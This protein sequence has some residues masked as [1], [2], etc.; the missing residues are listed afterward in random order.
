MNNVALRL[1]HKW[2]KGSKTLNLLDASVKQSQKQKAGTAKPTEPVLQQ[3][4]R[5]QSIMAQPATAKVSPAPVGVAASTGGQMSRLPSD[6]T[7]L[8]ESIMRDYQKQQQQPQQQPGRAAVRATM[9]PG[10]VSPDAIMAAGAPSSSRQPQQ[11]P[12]QSKHLSMLPSSSSQHDSQADL[13]R[14]LAKQLLKEDSEDQIQPL[15]KPLKQK[16]MSS[17]PDVSRSE[18]SL[19][20][21]G[22]DLRRSGGSNNRLSRN[23]S[24]RLSGSLNNLA[25]NSGAMGSIEVLAIAT[26][27]AYKSVM[28]DDAVKTEAMRR[29]N[30]KF[31]VTADQ[32]GK[33]LIQD[34]VLPEKFSAESLHLRPASSLGSSRNLASLDGTTAA[35]MSIAGPSEQY[36]GQSEQGGKDGGS[37]KNLSGSLPNMA[38]HASGNRA[39]L[40]ESAGNQ[41]TERAPAAKASPAP[42]SQVAVKDPATQRQSHMIGR[43]G[44]PAE[45]INSLNA[46]V[47]TQG[48]GA[49]AVHVPQNT[50]TTNSNSSIASPA[51]ALP[52]ADASAPSREESLRKNLSMRRHVSALPG[53]A[54]KYR[55]AAEDDLLHS[56]TPCRRM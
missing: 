26:A 38:D 24:Q 46:R 31:K 12:M 4:V 55:T 28:T 37:R 42:S 48:G 5:P 1:K 43:P 19:S 9:V 17:K 49:P 30:T 3:G 53:P 14:P 56:W 7:A 22:G 10:A 15:S 35:A 6:Q 33:S 25:R 16:G 52:A 41:R 51:M 40:L 45:S 11:P 32:A 2:R 20:G 13:I 50:S 47:R 8:E 18:A 44:S 21:S 54:Q 39:M 27:S 23:L 36:G 34:T 29:T